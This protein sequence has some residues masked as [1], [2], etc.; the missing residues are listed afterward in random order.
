MDSPYDINSIMHYQSHFF[1]TAE[2]RMKGEWTMLKKPE[3]EPVFPSSPRMTTTD[4]RVFS[5]YY[6]ETAI[7]I[8]FF[9]LNTHIFFF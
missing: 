2:A 1:L 7:F 4:S 9:A 3:M 8:I 6:D 5:F